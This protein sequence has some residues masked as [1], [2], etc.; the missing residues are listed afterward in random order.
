MSTLVLGANGFIGR[1]LV[2]ELLT[3]GRPV[4]AATRPGRAAALRDWLAAHDA[5]A[6]RLTNVTADITRPDLGLSPADEAR[7]HDVRDVPQ[8]RRALPLRPRPPRGPGRQPRRSA[9]RRP[10]GGRPPRPPPPGPPL[11]L[12]VSATAP[13]RCRPPRP[14]G[15][16]ARSA[17]TRPP[18]PRV[19]RPCA[20]WHRNSACRSA[21]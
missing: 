7:L 13:S 12:P 4:A 5:P 3:Q 9:A 21:W 16:T 18:S 6:D 1:W 2:L 19:T 15:C 8:P 11:R 14:T 10:L 17:P 20:P